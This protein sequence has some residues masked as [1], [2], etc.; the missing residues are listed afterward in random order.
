MNL[1]GL[2]T[3]YGAIAF[4]KQLY[5]GT[6]LGDNPPDWFFNMTEGTLAFEKMFTFKIQLLG[7]EAHDSNTWLWAWANEGSN[8]PPDLLKVVQQLRDMGKEY[9]IEAFTSKQAVE[10]TDQ[11]QGHNLS[12]IASGISGANAYYRGPYDGGAL[13]MIIEDDKYPV[14]TRHPMQRIAFTFP[15]FI[16]SYAYLNHEDALVDYCLAHQ[17]LVTVG[18]KKLT[19]EHSDNTTLTATFDEQGRLSEITTTLKPTSG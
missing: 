15:Q 17:L 13:F 5:L 19:A 1:Q 14:D 3:R 18:E 11:F 4:E 16:Q 7:T 12:L 10:M 9:N 6:L 2:L 8:I